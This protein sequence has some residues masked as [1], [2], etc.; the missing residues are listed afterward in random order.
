ME[1][2]VQRNVTMTFLVVNIDMLRFPNLY[3][4]NMRTVLTRI[5]V[6]GLQ[7]CG[8]V[9]G[10]RHGGKQAGLESQCRTLEHNVLS[11]YQNNGLK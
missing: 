6:E 2:G 5:F 3:R 4:I 1:G 11:K 9:L 10:K 8:K 7:E